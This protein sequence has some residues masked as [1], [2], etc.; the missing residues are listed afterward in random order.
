M[1]GAIYGYQLRVYNT[2][3]SG[4]GPGAER[5]GPA[6]LARTS[7]ERFRRWNGDRFTVFGNYAT[8]RFEVPRLGV[9][10]PE[11]RGRAERRHRDLAGALHF[12]CQVREVGHVHD[13]SQYVTALQLRDA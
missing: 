7:H 11:E 3:G 8:P 9:D 1:P 5:R 6:A 2:K 13:Y 10:V 12:F 4:Q